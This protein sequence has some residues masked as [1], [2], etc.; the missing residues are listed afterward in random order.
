[1][2]KYIIYCFLIL[3]SLP[4]FGD[5]ERKRKVSIELDPASSLEV[6][7]LS[8]TAFGLSLTHWLETNENAESL[9]NG[10]YEPSF[11]AYQHAFSNQ[12][13]IWREMSE[14]KN[15]GSSYMDDLLKVQDAGYLNEYIWDNHSNQTWSETSQDLK[16]EDYNIWA[17][18][19]LRGHKKRIEA[20]LLLSW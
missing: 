18:D 14:S 3:L 6:D 4:V 7:S 13:Q 8:A 5:G 1:M 16:L 9:P 12:I 11:S 17:D 10:K 15:L 19:N 20:Q 2:N